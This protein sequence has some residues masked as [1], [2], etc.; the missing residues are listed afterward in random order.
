M[1]KTIHPIAG[2][3]GFLTIAVF[4]FSTIGV[5][6][7]GTQE[8][9]VAVKTTIPWGFFVLVPAMAAVGG[10][11]FSLAGKRRGGILGSKAKRM[12]IIGGNGVLVLIPAA[13]FLSSKASAGEFDSIFYTVQIV[14]LI[15]GATNLT[16]MGLSMRD[17]LRLTG[18]L[19]P[20]RANT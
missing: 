6:L 3:I 18:R 7:F 2:G 16:L 1:T 4:W 19:R 11:G 13:L 14:E 5:E 17:G 12:K 9:I 10:S 15:A 20:R 8:Q